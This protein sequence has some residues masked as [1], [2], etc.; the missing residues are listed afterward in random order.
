MLF[1]GGRKSEVDGLYFSSCTLVV[2]FILGCTG[3]GWV[4][5]LHLSP[6]FMHF[7][8]AHVKG[9][10]LLSFPF[11]PYNLSWEVLFS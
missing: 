7:F 11:I 8:T 4:C 6:R 9:I 10:R 2:F 5:L 3:G 1:L